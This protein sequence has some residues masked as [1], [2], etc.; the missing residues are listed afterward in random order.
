[1]SIYPDKKNVSLFA[2]DAAEISLTE[3]EL[4]V[5][6]ERLQARLRF[7]RTT[8][9]AP[10]RNM[11]NSVGWAIPALAA[12]FAAIFII[13]SLRLQNESQ[14][15]TPIETARYI[16]H[17]RNSG[18]IVDGNVSHGTFPVLLTDAGKGVSDQM[19]AVEFLPY[20]PD[21]DVFKPQF[22]DHGIHLL[23]F[24]GAMDSAI[25][26]ERNVQVIPVGLQLVAGTGNGR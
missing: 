18:V 21:I 23:D 6:Y 12:L 16:N 1:M 10:A 13:P 7:C 3:T 11:K 20:L 4:A 14:F 22:P 2:A 24:S 15:I 19:Y 9:R 5:S 25:L 26:Y 8:K 17:L